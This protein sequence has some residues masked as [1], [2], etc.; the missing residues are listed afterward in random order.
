MCAF[1]TKFV[2]FS[3]RSFAKRWVRGAL[4]LALLAAHSIAPYRYHTF[5]AT[6]LWL[7]T[8]ILSSLNPFAR[9]IKHKPGVLGEPAGQ[10]LLEFC[11]FLALL[12]TTLRGISDFRIKQFNPI[13]TATGAFW[14]RFDRPV[15][16]DAIQMTD[17]ILVQVLRGPIMLSASQRA[18]LTVERIDFKHYNE[19]PGEHKYSNFT[20]GIDLLLTDRNRIGGSRLETLSANDFANQ[21]DYLCTTP[22][23]RLPPG[24]DFRAGAELVLN[25]TKEYWFHD[26]PWRYSSKTRIVA[27][28]LNSKARDRM[29]K[30]FNDS[31][32][33]TKR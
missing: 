7:V 20:Y 16:I 11:I 10:S 9:A 8:L 22:F 18:F 31:G 26:A 25:G 29:I 3:K 24:T 6:N 5:V 1:F 33:G 17:F 2:G 12:F 13:T 27:I 19:P 21:L 14:V 32:Q 30:E 4:L 15:P 23:L 28:P